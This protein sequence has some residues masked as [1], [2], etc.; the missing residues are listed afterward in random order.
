MESVE[1]RLGN[2]NV[3]GQGSL[4]PMAAVVFIDVVG[5]TRLMEQDE[6]GTHRHW[7]TIRSSVIGPGV[8]GKGG[9]I[10]KSTGDGF[11]L[12]FESGLDAVK[13]A[14]EMQRE[15]G[16]HAAG[17]GHDQAM[18]IRISEHYCEIIQE[19]DDIF[20]EG[21]NIAARLLPFADPG[22]IVIS[23]TVHDQIR[24]TL[25]FH[26]VDLGFLRLKNIERRVR[27]FKIAPLELAA[28]KAP[29]TRGHQPS[30]AVL[31]MR[32]PG[33]NPPDRYFAEGIVHDIVASLASV[34]ELFVVASSSTLAIP[35]T[36]LDSTA[37]SRML[38]V[39]YLL[40]GRIARAATGWRVIAELIDTDTRSV[41]WT[42]RFEFKHSELFTVQEAIAEKVVYA[43]LP[44]IRF[45]ELERALRKPPQSMDAYD[46]LL[47]GMY[48]LYR[49]REEDFEV[50]R[51]LFQ[52]AIEHDPSYATAYAMMAKW[53][54]LQIGEG[55][56]T[57]ERADD[58]EALRFASLAIKHSPS[59]PLAL[60]VYGHIQSFLFAEY[61]RA[62][63]SFNRAIAASPNSAI[64][65]GLSAP[66]Y[67]YIG[68]G[69]GAIDRAQHAL[70][71][72]PLEPFAYFYRTT[73]TLAYYFNDSYEDSVFWGRKSMAAAPRFTANMRPLIASLAALG[74]LD[75]AR[76]VGAALIEQDP[77][78]RV[79]KFCSRYPLKRL[80]HRALLSERL[81][82]A[83]LP[84]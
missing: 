62:I 26:L 13:F 84:K 34:R 11:L 39:Q 35:D 31:P 75:E 63:E 14:L 38:G 74:R 37:I 15:L 18:Q 68:D 81:L 12:T 9:H 40:T 53:Y 19:Q 51:A 43:L 28:P 5:Y 50:S 2:A 57:D 30:I 4:R 65:W 66:T 45:T 77:D 56:S 72:S 58:E 8:L 73:L 21:V 46:F 67:C 3:A 10:V 7:M 83:G 49:L 23:A 16:A 44:H 32:T 33:L 79:E 41:I 54:I 78:F 80:E 69:Q 20:G 70:S 22:G 36:T 48:R 59:D 52:K 47:Q 42:D 71:L 27:A 64:A 29:P 82:A 17:D 61:D 6:Q 25:Q 55:R 76:E 1:P 24:P 60:S